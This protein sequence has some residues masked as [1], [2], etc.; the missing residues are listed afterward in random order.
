MKWP[1]SRVRVRVPRQEGQYRGLVR[2][3]PGSNGGVHRGPDKFPR[4]N[5][6]RAVFLHAMAQDQQR[7]QID[8]STGT[9]VRGQPVKAKVKFAMVRDIVMA[10]QRIARHAAQGKDLDQF[11]GQLPGAMS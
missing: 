3:P 2:Y 11:L 9:L 8:P 5:A 4:R 7:E 10:Y 1:L 6:V